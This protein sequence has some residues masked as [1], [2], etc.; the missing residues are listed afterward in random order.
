MTRLFVLQD[1]RR[2]WRRSHVMLKI[3]LIYLLQYLSKRK[4][5]KEDAERKG[6]A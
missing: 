3:L 6:C 1:L 2:R 4:D 5:S